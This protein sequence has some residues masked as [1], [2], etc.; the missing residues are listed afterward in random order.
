[1]PASL[2]DPAIGDAFAAS[3]TPTVVQVDVN[4]QPKDVPTP[5][6]S[7]ADW[8][9]VSIY[10]LLV[11]RFNNPQAPP[12]H[13]PFDAEEDRLQGGTL[14]GIRQKIPYLK[15][16]GVGALWLSPVLKN[17]PHIDKF[18]GGYVIQDFLT[19]EP[20]FTSDPQAARN[21]PS[22]GER[23]LRALVDTAHAHGLYVIL[24]IVLNHAGDVFNYE[25][26]RDAAPWRGYPA[27]EYTIYWRDET[28]NANGAWTD[29]AQV[30]AAQALHADAAV[31]PRELQRND[32]FRRR[33]GNG[34]DNQGDFWIFKELVTEYLA[35]G[36]RFPVRNALIKAHQYLIAKYDV[37]G[38]RID[39]LM[40]VERDFAR[41]FGN[42]MR[43]FA[44]SI[45]KRNFFT[46][47]EVWQED[48]R[49]DERI[50]QFVGRNTE[51]RD[52]IVGVDA[53]LDFPV[54]RRLRD[55][56]K[57][58]RPPTDLA[59][60]YA[61]RQDALR[62]TVSSHGDAGRFFV[63]FLDNHDLNDRFYYEQPGDP[64]RYRPQFSL[65]LTCLFC[66][67]GIPCL[68]Y[69]NEQGLHGIGSRR[70]AAR[71]ALWGKPNAFSTAHPFHVA[72]RELHAL[73]AAQPA[74]RYG[75]QYFR[76]VSG[77][78]ATFNVSEFAGGVLAFSRILND[79]EVL[80][81]ANTSTTA[82]WA[83]FV[84]VDRD[85]HNAGDALDPLF[86]NRPAATPPGAVED[87]G[88]NRCVR[89]TLKPMEAQVLGRAR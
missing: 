11:D 41:T 31:W 37:D 20:R 33:G 85:L 30:A 27:P 22:L 66:L 8:R 71:E 25:G 65:A 34:P 49:A 9:D 26:A 51:D 14:E 32:Y 4:G 57:G 10:F 35:P 46:F 76:P 24:D 87:R 58:A 48:E 3:R 19:V 47:G 78:G 70:E 73:R 52:Q 72:V 17:S 54:F 55:V 77:D 61:Y 88:P 38:Y 62:H 63:T 60:Y 15:G 67:Q 79:E 68:Y 64:D 5:F 16:L 50:A 42:A 89:V 75:R 40:Y 39:T 44:L 59:G 28:G 43:E 56:C 21:D 1:M 81:L 23:E 53:A 69:G 74:L 29:I 2:I 86:S 7:P 18:Y 83:G 12:R 13:P 45:G 80:V 84:V 6:P 36:N 82:A